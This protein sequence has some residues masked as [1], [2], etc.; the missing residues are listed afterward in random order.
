MPP[1]TPAKATKKGPGPGANS[2]IPP[3]AF[4]VIPI[5][6]NANTAVATADTMRSMLET[7]AM[8]SPYRKSGGTVIRSYCC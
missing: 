7:R 6:M 4:R 1:N 8:T 5:Q 3:A 2:T